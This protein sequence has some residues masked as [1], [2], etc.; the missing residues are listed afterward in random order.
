MLMGANFGY[1]EKGVLISTN[2]HPNP[3][4]LYD[5]LLFQGITRVREKLAIIVLDNPK[6]FLQ[7]LQILVPEEEN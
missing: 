3:D 5:K 1:N 4:Y 7:I 6:L 2:A